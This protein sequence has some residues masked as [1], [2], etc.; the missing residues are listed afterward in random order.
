MRTIILAVLLLAGLAQ[1]S[2][3]D[4]PPDAATGTK[5]PYPFIS[6]TLLKLYQDA[7]INPAAA[8]KWA[9]KSMLVKDQHIYLEFVHGSQ[10]DTHLP[11]DNDLLRQLPGVELTT[12]F[13]NRSSAWVPVNQLL[14]I[15]QSLPPNYHLSE[16]LLPIEDNQGPSVTNSDSYSGTGGSGMLIAVIDSGFDSLAEARAA[17]AAPTNANTTAYDYSGTGIQTTTPH[18]TGCLET[19]FDHAPNAQYNIYKVVTTSDLGTAVNQCISNNVNVISHSVSWF[20]TGWADNSGAACSAASNAS[21][22]GI[23]FVNS[24]GNRHGEHWQGSFGDNGDGDNWHSWSSGGDE[25]NNFTL[26]GLGS[27]NIYLQ[28]NSSSGTDHYDLYLYNS[29]ST[30][31]ASSTNTGNFESITYTNP[32]ASAVNVYVAVLRT[33]ASPPQMELFIAGNNSTNLQHFSDLGSCTSP[34]NSTASNAV[35]VGAVAQTSFGQPGGTTGILASYSSR[36]P[37]NGGSQ[38]PDICGPT[39]TTTVAYNGAF[40]GTSCATPN[41][42]GAAAAFWSGHPALNATGVRRIL[43]AKADIYKDWGDNGADYLYGSGGVFL[44][45]Y[46]VSNRYILSSAG[47]T[48]SAATLPYYSIED[49]DNDAAVPENLRIYYLDRNATAPGTSILINKPMLYRSLPGTTID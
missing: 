34:S 42:A 45:D 4:I 12:T 38:A 28:W 21:S 40:T 48:S 9:E 30:L 44:F 13:V 23:L 27:I 6:S 18:G 19:V 1:A 14:E 43:L 24:C 32:S 29:S 11:I 41:V 26:S 20:N 16:A 33:T 5:N 17:S 36:G 10:T 25:Q 37:T 39:N 46:H 8:L 2:A 22:N 47:N 31:L 49:V 7:R 35:S 15:A 3:Q